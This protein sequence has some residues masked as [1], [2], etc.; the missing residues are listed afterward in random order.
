MKP[1][2]IVKEI[3]L[4][5][6]ATN[7][8]RWV[9]TMHGLEKPMDHVSAGGVMAGSVCTLAVL[10]VFLQTMGFFGPQNTIGAFK[11]PFTLDNYL[12]GG[13]D[14]FAGLPVWEP[15]QSMIV[16]TGAYG[17][18]RLPP[19]DDASLNASVKYATGVLSRMERIEANLV[20]AGV[21]PAADSPAHSQFVHYYPNDAALEK[22]LEAMVAIGASA[23]LTQAHCIRFGLSAIECARYITTVSL[24]STSLGTSCNAQQEA[25]C[26]LDSKY[27]TLD[28]S[29]NNLQNPKWGSA[30]TAYARL[31][32]PQ[33]A[34]GIQMPR[35]ERG[36]HSL[37]NA[38]TVSVA[39]VSQ[40]E[41]TDV[42]KTLALMEW[43]QFVSNDISY[44]PIRKMIWT[45]KA[46]SCCRNDGQWPLPRYI[47]PDCDAISVSDNDPI[48][49]KH[50]IR[51]LNYVRSL[52]VLRSD[53][54]F[55][56]AEQM[57]Q[58]SHFLDGSSI[59]GSTVTRSSEIRLFQ[60]GLLRVNVRNNREYMPV[61]HA[62][63][64]SQCSSK[65]CY[66]SGD[67]RANSEPQMAVMQTLWVREHNRIARKLAEVNPEWS[68]E[69]LYQEARR[70]VIAEI[71]HITYKEWL[72]QLLGKRYASS[73][74]L[75]VAGNYSGAPYISYGDPAVSNEVATAA[76]RF[77]QSL[78]QGK[79]RMTDND[80][81]INNS[82]KLSDYYY[83]PRSIEKSDVFDGLIRGLATQTAQKMD[84]HLVSD[85]SHELYKTSGEVG[86]DQ[87][88]LD[89][90]RGRDHGLPGYNHY[91][92]YCG[93]PSAKSFNDFL[94]YIPMGTV[95][96]WQ[97]LYKRPDDVDLVIGGMAE[98]PV[99]DALLGP[100]FRCLLATQFLRARRTD[101]FFYD[102]LDQPHPFN[103][104]QLNSLKKVT[105]ARIFCDNGDDITKMQP[106]VYL[107][108]QEGNELRPCTDF[109][110]I[111]SIDLFAWAE[112]AKAY[113]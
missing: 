3:M 96:K 28:G 10:C 23:Q 17:T 69:T 8:N 50:N 11:L 18:K 40:D 106:N 53:C 105:L 31:L 41:R 86:L 9:Y 7:N 13:K 39:L 16:D 19:I 110:K 49:G 43:S 78:K 62:E 111:P 21:A 109:E 20:N 59:Y 67:D 107:K 91:R 70:I 6:P 25:D 1:I 72:P 80:R 103:I 26:N 100:T 73:I 12:A 83:K 5:A 95:R 56:P 76:L 66:L 101:R 75:N 85:I 42:S 92:K 35:K 34:D 65:N 104:A 60:G 37:P 44:T 77:L 30:F 45:G 84:L 38:R 99:D 51:C 108:P 88:S 33:Y 4:L 61:A 112:K 57:N 47:H 87:I 90:Q 24:G 94:D 48:Y 58:V 79:L 71:Q 54:T 98:R 63:P 22:G 82:I 68:D 29:C 64:A 27:R 81:L 32:F 113:R 93:L 89:I 36:V 55:G 52:P 102:S 46:I 97:E 14:L 2:S 74:G 15:G